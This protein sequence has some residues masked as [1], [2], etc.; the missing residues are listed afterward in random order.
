MI[1]QNIKGNNNI[2][3]ANNNA[4]IIHTG[5]LKITMEIVHD[6]ELHI[7]DAQALQVRE[8][9]IECAMILASDGSNK[10]SLVKKQYGKLYK[11]FGITKYSLLPKDKFEEAMTWLQKEIAASRKVLKESDPEE[12]RKAH[13]KAINARGRQMG[14]D[15]EALLIYASQILSLSNPLF[16]LKYLNDDYMFRK[17]L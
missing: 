6:P 15:R 10:K 8:K 5:K 12:W 14:M 16:S 11:K 9:V 1:R 17:K 7:T 4:P 3:V 2:Q 13:Y